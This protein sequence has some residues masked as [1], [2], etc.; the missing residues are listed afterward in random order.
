[1]RDQVEVGLRIV[2]PSGK[3]SLGWD[4]PADGAG[5]GALRASTGPGTSY[6]LAKRKEVLAR[7]ATERVLNGLAERIC[8]PLAALATGHTRRV[9][10]LNPDAGVSA[11]FLLPEGHLDAFLTRLSG[12]RRANPATDIVCTGPWPPY[13]FVMI[14]E[15]RNALPQVRHD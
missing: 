15:P 12:I 3:G 7:A 4:E 2:V 11:A 5:S 13:S 6:L 9:D 1:M 10:R 14:D 8:P